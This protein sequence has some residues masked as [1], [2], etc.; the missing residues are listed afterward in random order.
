MCIRT[1]TMILKASQKFIRKPYSIYQVVTDTAEKM[2][3][4]A[5]FELLRPCPT[6]HMWTFA[7]RYHRH[8]K[9][10]SMTVSVF[11][12]IHMLRITKTINKL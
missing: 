2:N 4:D 11:S 12:A 6:H 7:F 10:I 5:T 1:S 9:T 3:K 8:T